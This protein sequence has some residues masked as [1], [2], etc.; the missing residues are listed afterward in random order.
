MAPTV[1]AGAPVETFDFQRKNSTDSKRDPVR[2]HNVTKQLSPKW[3]KIKPIFQIFY[4][5][6]GTLQEGEGFR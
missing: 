4:L 6:E 5:R 2:L 3:S 1:G